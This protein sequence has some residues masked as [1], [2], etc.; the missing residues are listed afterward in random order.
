[1]LKYYLHRTGQIP[2]SIHPFVK[3]GSS[4]QLNP[5]DMPKKADFILTPSIKSSN[6]RATYQILNT[7]VLHVLLWIL[8]G[9]WL[10]K[11][12]PFPHGFY[13]RSWRC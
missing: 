7:V 2:T 11:Q 8:Y 4:P 3:S 1:M 12:R 6:L 10:C 5:P 9:L 13:P